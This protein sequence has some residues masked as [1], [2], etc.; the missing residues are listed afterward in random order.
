MNDNLIKILIEINNRL[1]DIALTLQVIGLMNASI[2]RR[3]N[4]YN[5]LSDL[6]SM[7]KEKYISCESV[8]AL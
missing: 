5:F 4:G 1:N 7:Q 2:D 3:E 8:N 6:M